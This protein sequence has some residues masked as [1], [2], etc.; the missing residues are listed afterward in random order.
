MKKLITAIIFMSFMLISVAAF[1]GGDSTKCA[2]KYPVVLAHGMGAQAKIV[3]IVDYWWGIEDA[4]KDE[5]AQVYITSTM[6]HC[7]AIFIA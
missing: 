1:A 3:N 4:L 2:T 5:G 7:R 6:I